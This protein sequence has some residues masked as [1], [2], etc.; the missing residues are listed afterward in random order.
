MNF[1]AGN[2]RET[3]PHNRGERKSL[4][5]GQETWAATEE[6]KTHKSERGKKMWYWYCAQK[7]I[8]RK[9]G[10]SRDRSISGASRT[11]KNRGG[12]IRRKKDR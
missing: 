8:V 10:E 2:T 5:R 6:R 9:K 3:I 7:D 11:E 4:G 12:L 1:R